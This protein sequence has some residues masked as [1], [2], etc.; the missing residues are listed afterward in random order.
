[1]NDQAIL[2][3]EN[4]IKLNPWLLEN[5]CEELRYLVEESEQPYFNPGGICPSYISHIADG[6]ECCMA[7]LRQFLEQSQ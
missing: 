6:N 7:R 3:A 2:N 4:L 1:M 5:D